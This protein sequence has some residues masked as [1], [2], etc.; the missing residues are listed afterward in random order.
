MGHEEAVTLLHL[1]EHAQVAARALVDGEP[2]QILAVIPAP[3][4]AQAVVPQLVL[5]YLEPLLIDA[6]YPIA[7]I[8]HLPFSSRCEPEHLATPRSL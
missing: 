6:K 3:T 1:V 7:A 5:Q 2:A 4:L 8:T